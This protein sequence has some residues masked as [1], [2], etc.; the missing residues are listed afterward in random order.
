MAITGF[1]YISATPDVKAEL[2]KKMLPIIFGIVLIF[3]ATS[4]AAF[5]LQAI[6]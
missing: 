5:I 1:N 6:E 2:K 3:S 4:I